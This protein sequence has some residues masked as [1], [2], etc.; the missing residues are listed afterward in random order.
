MAEFFPQGGQA[1][2]QI[3]HALP[4]VGLGVSHVGLHGVT[5]GA[6]LLDLSPMSRDIGTDGRQPFLGGDERA[7]GG[8][9]F[10][11]ESLVI[12]QLFGGEDGLSF[13]FGDFVLQVLALRV[14]R[15]DLNGGRLAAQG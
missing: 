15:P 3:S 9:A 5:F 14:P 1:P 8:Q 12:L 7:F 6:Q 4:P 11:V 2:F 10:V 13:Q